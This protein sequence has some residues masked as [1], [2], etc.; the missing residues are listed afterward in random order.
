MPRKATMPKVT[1]SK[2]QTEEII[3][4]AEQYA[5]EAVENDLLNTDGDELVMGVFTEEDA[6]MLEQQQ[7]EQEE[8]RRVL[9]GKK[10]KRNLY[11]KG[12]FAAVDEADTKNI[13]TASDLRYEAFQILNMSL[14]SGA[15]VKG[16][17]LKAEQRDPDVASVPTA[18]ILMDN[19]S[20]FTI[21]IP[22][23]DLIPKYV[24]DALK[25]KEKIDKMEPR[26]AMTYMDMLINKRTGSEIYFVVKKLNEST[27]E[28]LAS[29]VEA[30]NF[31][32]RDWFKRERI[33][34]GLW[35]W[36]HKVGDN[37][38]GKVLYVDRAK[39]GVEVF[40]VE[41]ELDI[42]D[43]AWS[44]HSDLREAFLQ[45]KRDTISNATYLDVYRPGDVIP[46]K[47]MYIARL[48]EN[49]NEKDEEG[50]PIRYRENEVFKALSEGKSV[51][52]VSYL[53]KLSSKEVDENP[54]KRFFNLFKVG[55]KVPAKITHVDEYGIFCLLANK[56]SGLIKFNADR[57]V[58]PS[59]G[60]A[61]MVRITR[62]DETDRNG[63]EA[64]NIT[65][66][67]AYDHR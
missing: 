31:H 29:R 17:I 45:Y 24:M 28:V 38:V 64:W 26:A 44:R 56:R 58:L 7:K 4:N 59:P 55:D 21:K 54:E 66:E 49:R 36:V 39:M 57:P 65:C 60:S 43:I 6:K 22:F 53:L 32:R 2:E 35:D 13:I 11:R 50:N 63:K 25:L 1:T 15:P 62:M 16:T 10:T 34:G 14:L 5:Q 23:Q 51:K 3:R 9:A 30:M 20:Y 19:D 33:G 40:G 52:P 67:I 61:V 41:Q 42:S 48:F 47:V 46:L 8:Q 37:V 27:G 18:I 12:T